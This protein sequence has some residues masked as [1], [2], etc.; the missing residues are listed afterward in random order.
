MNNTSRIISILKANALDSSATGWST[1]DLAKLDLPIELNFLLPNN[2][3]L[4]HLAEKVVAELI[5]SSTNYKLL[6]E[7]VQVMKGNQTIGELDFVIEDLAAKQIIHMELAYKF[8]LYDP[9]ISSEKLQN[10]IGPNRNDSL[11]QKLEKLKAKQFPLLYH[12]GTKSLLSNIEINKV[13]QVLCFLVS[14]FVPYK[15]QESFSPAYRNAI[16]GYYL[17]LETFSRLDHS[18]KFYHVPSKKE[19]GIE[20]AEND[21][22]TDFDGVKEDIGTS[23]E[24]KQA[25]LCW[26]KHND[27]Y[28]SF[29]VVWW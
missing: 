26:R 20:P 15:Y 8:Y 23:I 16:K 18:G 25:L 29:F 19:W 6:Y 4:G 24:N 21:T 14:L 11:K 17:N 28:T 1:F 12:D 5:R 10:W 22:W 13:T 9:N 27:L 3:R 2:L 7:N